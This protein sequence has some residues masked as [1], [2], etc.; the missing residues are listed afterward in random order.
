MGYIGV[1]KSGSGIIDQLTIS[2][3]LQNDY[4]LRSFSFVAAS[5]ISDSQ[6]QAERAND[7]REMSSEKEV[8]RLCPVNLISMLTQSNRSM[9]L[10]FSFF[11]I[12]FFDRRTTDL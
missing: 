11:C 6:A 10:S 9:V 7:Y 1:F 2:R 4:L 3:I 8:A 12:H 5:T